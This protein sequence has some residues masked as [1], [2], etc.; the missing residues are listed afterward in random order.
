MPEPRMNLVIAP[1]GAVAKDLRRNS[2]WIVAL[3]VG[4]IVYVLISASVACIWEDWTYF[5]S[6][7]FTLINMTTVGFGDV[8]PSHAETMIVAGVNSVVGLLAFGA[9]VA[10]LTMA[11][12]P[13]SYQ[14]SVGISGLAD[15]V[16]EEGD[17]ASTDERLAKD[18]IKGLSGVLQ[19]AGRREGDDPTQIPRRVHLDIM[20]EA[21]GI[22]AGRFIHMSIRCH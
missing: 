20:L 22:G 6:C 8:V 17:V 7:Y 2:R 15:A 10:S 16:T 9:F 19:L 11:L 4:W 12:Q 13:S 14:G 5:R 18:F 21:E 3:L 1:V